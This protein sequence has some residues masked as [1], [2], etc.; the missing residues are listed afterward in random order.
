[1]IDQYDEHGR[2]TAISVQELEEQTQQLL[3]D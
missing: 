1:V 2:L 3:P